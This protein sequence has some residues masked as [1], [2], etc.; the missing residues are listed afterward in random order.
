MNKQRL[1][2]LAGVELTEDV[3][4]SVNKLKMLYKEVR[5]EFA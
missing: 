1:Q 3:K 2:E 5:N 4:G